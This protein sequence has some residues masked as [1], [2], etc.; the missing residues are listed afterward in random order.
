MMTNLDYYKEIT[1]YID[2]LCTDDRT[3]N[4]F[5]KWSDYEIG[6]AEAKMIENSC[7]TLILLR[8]FVVN[9]KPKK[10]SK[11]EM[12]EASVKEALLMETA[13]A[14]NEEILSRII[15]DDWIVNLGWLERYKLCKE[16]AR[17]FENAYYGTDEYDNFIETIHKFVIK[18]MKEGEPDDI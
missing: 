13:M 6:D 3:E 17:E 12:L 14:I 10:K 18:K 11:F 8:D 1:G 4:T 5:A 2:S 9:K 16:W 15:P 7:R